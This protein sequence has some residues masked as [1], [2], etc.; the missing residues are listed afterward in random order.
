[1]TSPNTESDKSID[2]LLIDFVGSYETFGGLHD[3]KEKTKS[4]LFVLL[5]DV[6]GEYEK[7][8]NGHKMVNDPSACMDCSNPDERWCRNVLRA[9]QRQKLNKLFNKEETS[10]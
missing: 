5:M 8:D 7:H 1:M 4:E 2:D 6:I 3:A 10:K 9:I